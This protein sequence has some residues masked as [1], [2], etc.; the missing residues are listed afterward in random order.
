M[1]H[2]FNNSNNFNDSRQ[3]RN[4]NESTYSN[5]N[6]NDKQNLIYNTREVKFQFIN[7]DTLLNDDTFVQLS[8]KVEERRN[9]S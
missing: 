1:I 9:K 6:D 5:Q 8:S 4:L 7:E 3:N 2:S